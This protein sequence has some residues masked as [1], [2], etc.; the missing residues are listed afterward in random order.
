MAPSVVFISNFFNYHQQA[1]A[2]NLYQL[3][4]DNFCFVETT[5]VS[6]GRISLG[7]SLYSDKKYIKQ[8]YASNEAMKEC[9]QS[10]LN[11]DVVIIG[12]APDI[13][14]KERLKQKKLTFRYQ[15]RPF[16]RGTWRLL[17]PKTCLKLLLSHIRY[18]KHPLYMLCASAYTA[19]DFNLI[20]AYCHKC[21]KWGYFPAVRH[22]DI[23]S[24]LKKKAK[25]K[26][27]LLWVARFLNWKHPEACL[28]IARELKKRNIDFSIT[29]IGTGELFDYYQRKIKE[30]NLED[31][32]LMTGA[33]PPEQVRNYMEEADIFLFTSD[34]REGWGAVLNE[35]MNSGCAVVASHAIG[36]VPYLIKHGENGLIFHNENW[37]DLLKWVVFLITN[38]DERIRLGK[39][40][41]FTL[42]NIWNADIAAVRLLALI[43]DI[44][45]NGTSTRF[46]N[47]ICSKAEIIKNNWLQ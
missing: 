19:H 42:T 43:Q 29:M 15:E 2:D 4:G 17:N 47:D 28:F 10:A 37:N 18:C 21:Y 27:K 12:S 26:I 20:G 23:D 5:P 32:I 33:M 31:V 6:Q 30:D 13:F 7:W 16:K 11:S 45:Q 46:K 34:F 35:S 44:Q 24:L 40:A 22:Y 36:S 38:P 39:S 14:I 41:Y 8:A 25:K 9:L 1:L 3:L